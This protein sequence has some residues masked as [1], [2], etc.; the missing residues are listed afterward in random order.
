VNN[1]IDAMSARIVADEARQGQI[2]SLSSLCA[3]APLRE[4]LTPA[5]AQRRKEN[6]L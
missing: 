4:Y 3:F 6:R 1:L 2:A 5:K